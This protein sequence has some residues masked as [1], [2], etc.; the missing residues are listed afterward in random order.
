MKNIFNGLWETDC[1]T[2]RVDNKKSAAINDKEKGPGEQ[3][4]QT[5]RQHS[6]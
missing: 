1:L 2:G 6:I 4:W 3:V 5:L